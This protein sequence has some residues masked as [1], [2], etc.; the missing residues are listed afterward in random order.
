VKKTALIV[1]DGAESIKKMAEII[2][3][4]LE[5]CKVTLVRAE[6]F[7]GTQLLPADICFFGAETPHPS[8]FD[9]LYTMLKHINLSGRPCG[10]F[11][12]S[13][14]ALSYLSG[15]VRD[16]ELALYSSPFPGKGDIKDWAEKVAGSVNP[17]K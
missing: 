8:S 16:S 4:A 9:Y 7:Q 13:E 2:G 5:N 10:I 17:V 14:E 11:S 12:N 3:E 6:D 1:T 15:M